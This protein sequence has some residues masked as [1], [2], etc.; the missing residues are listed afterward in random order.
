MKHLLF[1]GI[2]FSAFY[3]SHSN[4]PEFCA[5]GSDEG[6]GSSFTFA[7]FYDHVKDQC[8]PFIYKGQGGNANRFQNE[9]ECI[10]NCSV[11]ADKIYPMDVSQACHFKKAMGE[12]SAKLLRYYYDSVHHKCKKFLWSGCIGNGNRFTDQGICNTTCSGIHDVGDE[13]EEA[14]PDT[15]IAII[16]GVLLA[17]IIAS[18]FITVIVL[19]IQSKKKNPKKKAQGKS[20]EPQSA[21][22]L[23]ER[24]MEMA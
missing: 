12:C 20:E 21:S 16:C 1:L 10:R 17:A 13:E 14:E 23:Q 5:L 3:I 24:G 7:L 22:P 4:P 2:A 8:N 6:E 11:N 9:R 18:I 15:P 19:T